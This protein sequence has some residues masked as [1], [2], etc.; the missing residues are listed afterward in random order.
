MLSVA[1][2]LALEA[3]PRNAGMASGIMGS[4]QILI[5][6]CFSAGLSLIQANSLVILHLAV[7]GCAAFMAVTALVTRR[8]TSETAR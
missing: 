5:G 4:F 3:L 6:A 2:T 7:G 1:A 8:L